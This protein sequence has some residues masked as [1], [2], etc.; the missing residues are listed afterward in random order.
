MGTPIYLL[1]KY[2]QENSKKKDWGV[3]YRVIG[4]RV[5]NRRGNFRIKT[6]DDLMRVI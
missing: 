4:V 1:P 3:G 2:R 6:N 5:G